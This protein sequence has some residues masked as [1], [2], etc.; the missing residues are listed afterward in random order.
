[1]FSVKKT[2]L[3]LNATS[4]L[5]NH[6]GKKEKEEIINSFIYSSFNYCPLVLHFCSC[7]SSNKI[8]QTQKRC[9][10]ITLNDNESDYKTLLGKSCE[11]TMDIE[12]MRNIATEI[13]K[14][15]NNLNPPFLKEIFKAKVN[16]QNDITVKTHKYCY[17]RR[18]ISHCTGSKNKE[19]SP[20]KCKI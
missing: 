19:F 10:R 2:S 5:Q 15:I 20:K 14:T 13:F 11:A 8:G 4:R 18:Q 1:M 16:D 17:L 3:Q 6:M 12:R 9:L 7:K